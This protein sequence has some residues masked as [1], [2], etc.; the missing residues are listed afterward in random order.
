MVWAG[1]AVFFGVYWL[2]VMLVV[3]DTAWWHFRKAPAVPLTAVLA[4]DERVVLS[5]EFRP[6]PRSLVVAWQ[7]LTDRRI[8]EVRSKLS[9]WNPFGRR[10]ARTLFDF[11]A[12]EDV[13]V[14][15][16][17]I[18]GYYITMR[19]HTGYDVPDLIF[20]DQETADTWADAIRESIAALGHG[21]Q[22]ES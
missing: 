5:R 19:S 9:W 4:A 10:P 6:N 3:A 13:K 22:S 17:G 18:R 11:A 7:V 16:L 15:P 14:F 1:L 21:H 20:N 8:F 2:A 12:I